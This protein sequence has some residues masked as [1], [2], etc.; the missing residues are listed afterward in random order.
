MPRVRLLLLLPM[1][2]VLLAGCGPR[3]DQAAPAASQGSAED[4]TP[5]EAREELK[6]IGVGY[7]EYPFLFAVK[8]G[9]V[10]TV[11]LFLR[12]G[13]S[14]DTLDAKRILNTASPNTPVLTYAVGMSSPEIAIALI[15][16]GADI[17]IKDSSGRTPLA[18]AAFRGK[19]EIVKALIDAGADVNAVYG[20]GLTPLIGAVMGGTMDP[21]E[22]LVGTLLDA[23]VGLQAE[24]HGKG[25]RPGERTATPAIRSS[26]ETVRALIDAGADVN[27]QTMHGETALMYAAYRGHADLVTILLNAGAYPD[28]KN[29]NGETALII[30]RKRNHPDIVAL[31]EGSGAQ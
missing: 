12:A 3:D 19:T 17:G 23:A 4:M 2:L 8:K 27:A 14:P 13:M 10:D 31:L 26:P 25:R 21:G 5:A 16:A 20:A 9:D 24:L 30:G 7:G 6:R 11:R 22:A 1:I 28:F 18:D 29:M 15:E